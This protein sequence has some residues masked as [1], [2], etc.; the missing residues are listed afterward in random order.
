M[1]YLCIYCYIRYICVGFAG[2][3]PI[4]DTGS[5]VISESLD[6]SDYLD[7]KYPNPPLYP[8]DEKQKTADKELILSCEETLP[9]LLFAVLFNNEHKKLSEHMK[10]VKPHLEKLE[11]EL[12]NR[13]KSQEKRKK[14]S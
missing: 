3:I 14:R 2:K 6:I 1:Y 12:E 13:G 7:E 11:H 10:V 5:Q 8:Q 4:L 9:N